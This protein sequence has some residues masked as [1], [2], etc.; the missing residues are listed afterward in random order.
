MQVRVFSL[1]LFVAAV[2]CSALLMGGTVLADD[3]STMREAQAALD[4]ADYDQA[5]RVL[6][7]L[8]DELPPRPAPEP[9]AAA[10]K[11]GGRK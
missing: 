3:A 1:S 8:V 6:K 10:A 4:K 7:P 5:V 11:R 2:F 9:A